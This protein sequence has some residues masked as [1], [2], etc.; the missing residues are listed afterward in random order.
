MA[1]HIAV[2]DDEPDICELVALNLKKAGY[3]AS[4]FENAAEFQRS[5]IKQKPDLIILDL[6]LPDTD[7]FEICKFL[8]KN[9]NTAMIPVMMLT[10][11]G[12]ET[13]KVV[14]LELGADDYMTKPFSVKELIA[15]VKALLRRNGVPVTVKRLEFKGLS[16]DGATYTVL[17]KGKKIELTTTE[18]KILQHLA[19]H[20]GVVFSREKIL[21]HLWGHEKAVTDRT[22]DVHIKHLREKLGPAGEMLKNLR[23]V[24]YKF[25][26]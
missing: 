1:V 2:I 7:G 12:D 16:I 11:R 8:K 25:D 21:D 14:G 22:V 5:L 13:D 24:G 23:G 4:C 6:M 10:A 26:V 17:V 18:F 20:K 15:R 3:S 19:A 9:D